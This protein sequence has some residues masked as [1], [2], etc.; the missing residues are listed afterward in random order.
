[1]RLL[2]LILGLCFLEQIDD[3]VGYVVAMV[4]HFSIFCRF[5]SDEGCV[6]DFGYFSEDFGLA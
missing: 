6:V 2:I 4:A 5:H 3:N 1:M